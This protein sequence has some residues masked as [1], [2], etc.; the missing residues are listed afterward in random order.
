MQHVAYT[1]C[2]VNF[3]PQQLHSKVPNKLAMMAGAVLIFVNRVCKSLSLA[4]QRML[5]LVEVH[6]RTCIASFSRL[7]RGHLPDCRSF[8]CLAL[9]P[10]AIHP[11]L[12]LVIQRRQLCVTLF[13]AFWRVSQFPLP[14]T[15]STHLLIH[16]F[17]YFPSPSPAQNHTDN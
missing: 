9:L 3:N 15:A 10:E 5:A 4:L 7:Q 1:Y 14:F 6:L 13:T 11:E 16:P 8:H 12:C 17:L 2:F